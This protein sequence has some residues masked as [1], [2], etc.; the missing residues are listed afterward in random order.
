MSVLTTDEIG[1]VERLIEAM[2][3]AISPF[4]FTDRS[5]PHERRLARLAAMRA[6]GVAAPV[7]LEEAANAIDGPDPSDHRNAERVRILRDFFK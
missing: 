6:L 5:S 2:A 4:A 7:I 3:E 1:S